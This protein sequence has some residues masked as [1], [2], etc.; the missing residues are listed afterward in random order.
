MVPELPAEAPVT[1]EGQAVVTP[2]REDLIRDAARERLA[3]ED[4]QTSARGALLRDP[5]G[6]VAADA[7]V[8]K[9]TGV[10]Y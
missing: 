7:G 9:G 4:V 5:H 6:H 2:A 1:L 3:L 10:V 8:S